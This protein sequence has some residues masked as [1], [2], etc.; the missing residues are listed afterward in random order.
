MK[1]LVILFVLVSLV[2]S[3]VS[4]VSAVE[5]RA[6][7][8]TTLNLL[9]KEGYEIDVIKTYKE[10]FEK[11]TGIKLNIEVYDEP[12]TRQKYIFDVTSQSGTYDITSVSFWYLPEYYRNGW[13]ASLNPYINNSTPW[14]FYMDD[15]PQ[16]ALETFSVD[17]ELY[18]MPHTIIGGA[19]YYRK[20]I[21]EKHGL[22]PPK[23]TKDIVELAKQLDKLEEDIYPI[24]GRGVANF[25]SFGSYAGWAWTYG[26]TALN[27]NHEPQFNS[28]EWKEAMNDYAAILRDY[29][30]PGI[31][32]MNFNDIGQMFTEGKVAMMYDT[33]GWGGM[34]NNP[35]ISNVAG[36][37]GIKTISGPTGEDL[38]WIY[39]EGLGI[40]KYSRNKEA[41]MLF[42]QWRMSRAITKK[43]A[44]ELKRWDV[45]NLY[46]LGLPEYKELAAENNA[47][48]YVEFLPKTWASANIKYW[49][50]IPEFIEL[51]DAFMKN[52]SAALAEDISIEKALEVSQKEI[53][54]ILKNA[55]Y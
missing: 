42:L 23:T 38:Q 13:L 3:A 34:I 22:T 39:M 2:F 10:E 36:K 9:L 5:K 46:V 47:S 43:E 50:W 45:P 44:I 6:Y 8:G 52:M 4:I 48:N 35:E 41:A 14:D 26:A 32:S 7:E 18:A 40:N 30:P 49:P 31:A 54:D 16:S 29:G 17:G 25:S 28:P 1:K 33:S 12:T 24:I 55:G 37:V 27:E 53:K 11:E 21:F 15:V 20:D 19:F 51:G